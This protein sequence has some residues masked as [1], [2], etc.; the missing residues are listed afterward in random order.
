MTAKCRRNLEREEER[1]NDRILQRERS[2]QK[3]FFFSTSIMQ[4]SKHPYIDSLREH[5]VR[6]IE[7]SLYWESRFLRIIGIMIPKNN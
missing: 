7:V 2:G 3:A 5:V 1:T 4:K 6:T